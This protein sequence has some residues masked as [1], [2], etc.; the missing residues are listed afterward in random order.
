M[1]GI[2]L[3]RL[4]LLERPEFAGHPDYRASPRS[5]R[6]ISS[7]IERDRYFEKP[8]DGQELLCSP[9]ADFWKAHVR[10]ERNDRPDPPASLDH[11]EAFAVGGRVKLNVIPASSF[12]VAPDSATMRLDD[13]ATE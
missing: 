3:R 5:A 13:R 6:S 8:F 1:D 4:A 2:E 10:S 11:A 12:A 7:I 9:S